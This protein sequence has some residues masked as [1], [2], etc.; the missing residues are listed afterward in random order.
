MVFP[1]K[2]LS[3]LNIAPLRFQGAA[4]LLFVEEFSLRNIGK[5]IIYV[6]IYLL[7]KHNI[8]E[9]DFIYTYDK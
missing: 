7:Y 9:A 8:Y 4:K 6:K 2:S 5:T 3:E 1:Q